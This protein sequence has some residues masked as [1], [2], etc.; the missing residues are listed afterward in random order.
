MQIQC[1]PVDV[2][3][4]PIGDCTND[5]ISARFDELLVAC[6]SGPRRFFSEHELPLNFCMVEQ[7]YGVAH[8]VPAVVTESG[9]IVPRP[10]WWM[11][12]GN[13]ADTCDSRWHELTGVQYPLHIHD[14][15]EW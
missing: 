12:G 4:F 15:K 13:I 7:I 2:Y 6:P 10:G 8:I 5:G 1:L 9:K 3:R 11:A 14:R